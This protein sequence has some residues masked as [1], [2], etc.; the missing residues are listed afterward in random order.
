V[1]PKTSCEKIR[2]T[3]DT[4][5]LLREERVLVACS[6]GA[7]S[8][9]LL[10]ALQEAEYSCIAA[11]VNH[12]TR[13]DESDADEEFVRA[14]CEEL[15]IP[16][17]VARLSSCPHDEASL[18]AA[19]Y[20]KLVELAIEY[21][22]PRIAT[23]HT[24]DDVLETILLHLLRDA[25]ARGWSGIPP[26]RELDDGVLLVRP[27]LNTTR[28]DARAF[29]R[30]RARPWREDSSNDDPRYLRNRV[31]HELLPKL[32]ELSGVSA[33]R[34]ARQARRSG[35]VLREEFA[36]LDELAQQQLQNLTLR[37]ECHLLIL[38]GLKF[39]SL[40]IAL[41]RRVLRLAAQRLD[42]NARELSFERVEEVR[43]HILANRRRAVWQWRKTLRVEWT[44]EYSGNRI[45][46]TR[47]ETE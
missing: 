40:P 9:A 37:A 22:C 31:R 38:N 12:G 26:Q 47:L 35:E 1:A 34:L 15:R 19:R 29:L 41:Q 23:G 44:G 16:C 10:L 5:L 27:M 17:A 24:A 33:S 39:R 43:L 42:S 45:R 4:S 36:L 21:S 28:E 3:L 18:R 2:L 30:A 46:F 6:G 25:T 32:V 13:G 7:D 14:A 11:H 20:A 8:L